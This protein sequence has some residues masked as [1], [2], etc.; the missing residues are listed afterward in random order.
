MNTP[1]GAG[2]RAAP[3]PAAAAV[4]DPAHRTVS[5]AAVVAHGAADGHRVEIRAGRHLLTSDGLPCE[6]GSDAG[7]SPFGLLLCALGAC[8]VMTL[9]TYAGR[10]DVA[11]D[12]IRVRLVYETDGAPGGD[13]DAAGAVARVRRRITLFGDLDDARRARLLEVAERTP[14]TLAVRAGIRI[15]TD[16]ERA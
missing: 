8:T 3:D 15:D 9:R 10:H 13:G 7:P 11:L 4:P 5:V 6:G 2:T 1:D 16:E 12:E 14:V